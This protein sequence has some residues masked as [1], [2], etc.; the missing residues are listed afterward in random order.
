MAVG[1][2]QW[3]VPVAM[4]VLPQGSGCQQDSLAV[5]VPGPVSFS[6]D[7]SSASSTW[8]HSPWPSGW[9]PLMVGLGLGVTHLCQEQG[10]V[11]QGTQWSLM[12][13]VLLVPAVPWGHRRLGAW[14]VPLLGRDR[15]EVKR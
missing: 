12:L 7:P 15:L 3:V 11:G 6:Q 14:S 4:A 8:H 10:T 1:M 2:T 9:V 13:R 5:L